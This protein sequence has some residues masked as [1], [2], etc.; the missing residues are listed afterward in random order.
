M[1][2][3]ESVARMSVKLLN[4]LV[5]KKKRKLN[6]GNISFAKLV[7]ECVC[8]SKTPHKCILKNIS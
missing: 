7:F 8:V 3:R 5:K 4:F 2:F 1:V 6:L